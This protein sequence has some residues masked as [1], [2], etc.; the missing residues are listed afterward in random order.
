MSTEALLLLQNTST[1]W[2]LFFRSGTLYKISWNIYDVADCKLNHVFSW[3]C[4]VHRDLWVNLEVWLA[5]LF[6]LAVF[7][8]EVT[9]CAGLWKDPD[10]HSISVWSTAEGG[11]HNLELQ[12]GVTTWS[13]VQS[14]HWTQD[15]G[16]ACLFFFASPYSLQYQR[17][18]DEQ[19]TTCF[20]WITQW[21]IQNEGLISQHS[22]SQFNIPKHQKKIPWK[23]FLNTWDDHVHHNKLPVDLFYKTYLYF[24]LFL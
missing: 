11:A 4:C 2:N 16:A 18:V 13:C 19:N 9:A 5:S 7:N 20:N 24:G 1:W 21:N 23:P 6:S 10:H 3:V 15:E 12:H 14:K 17:H 22:H 8:Q